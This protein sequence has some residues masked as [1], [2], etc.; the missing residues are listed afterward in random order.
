MRVSETRVLCGIFEN[1]KTL[2]PQ[3]GPEAHRASSSIGAEVSFLRDK[4]PERDNHSSPCN[5]E[6]KNEWR[7]TSTPV[8]INDVDS[9]TFTFAF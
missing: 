4:W 6:V 3:K 8:C 7:Y 9:E 2:S 5:V 1:I